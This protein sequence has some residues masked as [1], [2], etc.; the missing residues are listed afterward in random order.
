MNPTS[1]SF[2]AAEYED[3]IYKIWM[4]SGAFKPSDNTDKEPFVLMMPP[5]NATGTLHLGHAT[6][7]AVEDIMVRYKRMQGHPTLYL[8]GTDHAAIAT[9]SVVEKR[10]QDSGI[11]NPLEDLGREGLLEKIRE[12][13]AGS[14]ATIRK[15]VKKM[16]TSCD[17][18]REKYTFSD[19]MN[20]S[21]NE[22][23]RMM[24]EDGL[25]YRGGRI[26]NWDP[27]MKSTVSDDELEYVEEQSKFYYFQYGPVVIGTARPETKFADKIIVVHPDDERYKDIVGTE[28]DVEWI[29]GTIK[30]RVIADECVDPEMGTGA[31]TITPAHSFVDY[32]LAQR[33]KLDS[34]QI[35]DFDG[36]IKKEF[37]ES[38]GGL[39]TKEARKKVVEILDKKGLVVKIDEN[40]MH[41]VPVNYRGKGVVEPQIMEQWFLDVN[42]PVMDWKGKNLSIKE[43]LQ[44]VVNSGMINII[45]NRFN[46]IY[47]HWIDNLRDWCLSRQIIW[48]H[49]IPVWYK[50]GEIKAQENSPGEGWTQDEDTLDTWFSSGLWTFSTL[51]WPKKTPDL[52]RF[53][54]S[55]VLETGYDILFFW[56]ARMI[57]QTTYAMRKS[58][59][60]EEKSIPFKTVYLHG[61]VRD[62]NG[63]KMSKSRPETCINPLD[64]IEK[65][66]TDA[67]RLSLMIGSTPGNDM[68]LY[69]EKISGYRNFVNKIWNGSRFVMMNLE[70]PNAVINEATLSRSD[71][72]ILTRLNEIISDVTEKL[73]AYQFS[74]AGMMI[75]DFF[76]GEF[77]DWYVEMSKV[78]KNEAVLKHVLKTSLKLMHPF[79]PFVTEAIWENLK[80]EELLITTAWPEVN[81][82]WNFP[83]ESDEMDRVMQVVSAIRKLRAEARVDAVKKIHAIIFAHE[84]EALIQDKLEVIKRLANLGSLDVQATGEKVEKALATFVGDVEIYLPLADLLDIGVEKLRISKE[85]KNLEGYFTGLEKKLS[86]D[87]FVGNAPAEVI[88][89]E[90]GKLHEAGVKLEKLRVQLMELG[91]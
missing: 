84:D 64:M 9:Q 29:D 70:D 52:E 4:D 13:V 76:W 15:Q 7:L 23:F 3:R 32:E 31:M 11:K 30:A 46:K 24:F 41:S 43:V 22:L 59:F 85:I 58:G 79:M 49:R 33:H 47:F 21:V 65:Y 66:G 53:S 5:P 82:E 50:D 6:M 14:Q 44:D 75:Y 73:E 72:W 35:I 87:G 69:E 56:V 91:E 63:K 74:D 51:G 12:F 10:L 83:S 20:H 17:W 89:K 90:K 77:C 38:C 68:R 19:E 80:E 34:P 78:I 1:T 86:N 2:D 39:T 61:M 48:G 57:I 81:P 18:S 42:K 25:I 62:V 16:G 26:V 45:P 36:C 54:P 37:S 40:Y 27:K 28:F 71:K 55:S 67:I 60:S 8:P 88:E